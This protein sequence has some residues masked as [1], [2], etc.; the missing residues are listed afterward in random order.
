M[1]FFNLITC[2]HSL[3]ISSTFHGASIRTF[4]QLRLKHETKESIN[5]WEDKLKIQKIYNFMII[6]KSNPHE[7]YFVKYPL[8]VKRQ[9]Q[10]NI[11]ITK[12]KSLSTSTSP[13][14]LLYFIYTKILLVKRLPQLNQTMNKALLICVLLRSL[15]FPSVLRFHQNLSSKLF[16]SK[17]N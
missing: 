10:I 8:N 14:L 6:I 7:V 11:N 3:K 5:T 4:D 15:Y 16:A 13:L 2:H 9:Y 1:F 17:I 12:S